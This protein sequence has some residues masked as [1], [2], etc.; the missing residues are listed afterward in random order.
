MDQIL[1]KWIPEHKFQR[2]LET[3]PAPAATPAVADTGSAGAAETP[4]KLSVAGLAIEGVNTVQGFENAG[5]DEESYR[6]MLDV[7]YP[8]LRAVNFKYDL[9]RVG[10]I[11]DT[12]HTTVP[13]TLYARGVALLKGRKYSDALKVLG[14]F[15]DR[16]AAICMLSL[17][18]DERAYNT[19]RN[20]PENSTHCYLMAVACARLKRR[21]QAL[22]HF[23]R[24][25][26][27]NESIQYR[28]NLDPEI[29]T[30]IKSR[31][32]TDE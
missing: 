4:A 8:R 30:L 17:G 18:Y 13:D 19:L 24:A 5:G 31:N 29:S 26:E 12:I 16:N 25:V 32:G 3:A 1:K 2:A 20:L 14:G 28:G 15:Y 21:E 23:D 27:L 11:K 6:Y 22:V 9:R 7:L 10:M